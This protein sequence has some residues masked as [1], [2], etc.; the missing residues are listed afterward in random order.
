M[1]SSALSLS[2]SGEQSFDTSTGPAIYIPSRCLGGSLV[3]VS[4]VFSWKWV[5]KKTAAAGRRNGRDG[6]VGGSGGLGA[7][8]R[9]RMT[10]L[11]WSGGGVWLYEYKTRRWCRGGWVE[12]CAGVCHSSTLLHYILSKSRNEFKVLKKSVFGCL[13]WKKLSINKLVF[14]AATFPYQPS[15]IQSCLWAVP[16]SMNSLLDSRETRRGASAT[17]FYYR[18]DLLVSGWED[19]FGPSSDGGKELC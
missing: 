14:S 6:E 9:G 7:R 5:K 10:T 1:S 13:N 8:E 3:I 18:C 16:F 2:L 11:R 19:W 4:I 12:C 15:S 17:S